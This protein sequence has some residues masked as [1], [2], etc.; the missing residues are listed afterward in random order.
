MFDVV[1]K[2]LNDNFIDMNFTN[3]DVSNIVVL[4]YQ[5]QRLLMCNINK[6]FI[7]HICKEYFNM[8]RYVSRLEVGA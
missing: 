7:Y 4:V 8:Q 5:Y 1:Q 6:M 2:V 3:N